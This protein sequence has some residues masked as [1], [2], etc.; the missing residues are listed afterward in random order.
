MKQDSIIRLMS[1]GD[2]LWR[3]RDQAQRLNELT[4]DDPAVKEIPLRR[5]VRSLGILL[6]NILKEQVGP[7]LFES[8]EQLRALA[9]RHR[10]L[11]KREV[12]VEARENSG[13]DAELMRQA[14][15][16]VAQM[17]VRD[18][19][20]MTK[21]FAI[22]FELAN[23]AETNHRKRRKRAAE[24]SGSGREPMPGSFRGTLLRMRDSGIGV[25]EAL[26][27]LSHIMAIPVFTA[28]PTEVA[29]RTVL[30]KR[31]R[32]ASALER[33][34]RLPLSPAEAGRLAEIVS[35]E[36]AGLWQS[37][38]VRRRQPIVRD[39]VKM[40]LDYYPSCL[41]ETLPDLYEEIAA[42]FDDVYG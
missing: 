18:A 41:I 19:Y 10:D 16:L 15:R 11:M 13:D 25:D 40:G 2:L 22:Y 32:I 17:S 1:N 30:F 20:R 35:A 34:D 6:G 33:L 23:L 27:H 14:A 39:E 38:E 4:S 37:D 7:E 5:D 8:V 26:L 12:T 29:R 24:V 3:T 28:H 9:I 31:R 21:A 42:A 36:I